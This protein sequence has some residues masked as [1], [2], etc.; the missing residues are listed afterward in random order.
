MVCSPA[1]LAHG[2]LMKTSRYLN[3]F[4]SAEQLYDAVYQW[5]KIGALTITSTSLTFF[6]DIYPSAAVGTYASTSSTFTSI[7]SAVM[8]YADG[9]MS[10]AVSY[11]LGHWKM[12]SLVLKRKHIRPRAA[13]WLSNTLVPMAHHCPPLISLGL[14][15]HS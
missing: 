10:N 6:Q 7:V 12:H 11:V 13:H 3:T 2:T 15:Q 9:Y 4:A 5:Q 1:L 14:M 8:T